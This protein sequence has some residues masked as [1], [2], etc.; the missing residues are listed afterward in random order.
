MLVVYKKNILDKMN[1]EITKANK[2]GREIKYFALSD[3][4]CVEY[5]Y[6]RGLDT[7][8]FN[9]VPVFKE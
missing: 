6:Y 2:M 5:C 4:E 7:S 1:D 9:G 8:Q 3:D